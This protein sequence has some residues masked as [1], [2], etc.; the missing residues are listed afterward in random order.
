MN[1]D[2]YRNLPKKRMAAGALLLNEQGELLIVKPA[3]K[4]YWSIA[5]GVIEADESPRAGCLREVREE[6]SIELSDVKLLGVDYTS[7]VGNKG[8]SLQFIFFGGILAENQIANIRL[9][10]SELVDYRFASIVQALPLL[11]EKLQLRLPQCLAALKNGAAI[12]LEDGK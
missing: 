7:N 11:S 3:N 4:D 10:D 6:L 5:G 9:D 12:Y 2:Y 8:D 1:D